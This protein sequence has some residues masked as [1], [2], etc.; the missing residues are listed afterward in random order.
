MK[1]AFLGILGAI[2][3]VSVGTTS[4]FAA[5]SGARRNFVDADSDGVCDNA[6]SNVCSYVD[7]DG[8]GV[9]DNYGDRPSKGSKNFVDEDSDGICDNFASGQ[10]KGNGHRNGAQGECGKNFVDEDGDGIC[11]NITSREGRGNGHGLRQGRCGK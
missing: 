6:G 9:C 8:D 7:A 2:I 1:K 5:G 11:D 4:A 3:A 10:G